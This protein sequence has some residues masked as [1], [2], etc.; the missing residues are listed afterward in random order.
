MNA[1][2]LDTR[3]LTVHPVTAK[4]W[5]QREQCKQCKHYILE[6]ATK[7][8][9]EYAARCDASRLPVPGQGN[10]ATEYCIDARAPAEERQDGKPGLCG[11]DAV[12][13]EPKEGG[14]A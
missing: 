9:G 8:R 4:W 5:Q 1:L 13:F 11:P 7:R 12:L 14:A 2:T 10:R 6:D 3:F